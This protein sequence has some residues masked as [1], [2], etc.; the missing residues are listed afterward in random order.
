MLSANL[1]TA[2]EVHYSVEC[3]SP[4]GCDNSQSLNM[5]EPGTTYYILTD[6]S[7][8]RTYNITV[9]VTAQFDLSLINFIMYIIPGHGPVASAYTQQTIMTKGICQKFC[10]VN[11]IIAILQGS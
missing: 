6:I 5:T 4:N 7:L 1:L 2:Y 3:L 8:W 10:I 11:F 9:N